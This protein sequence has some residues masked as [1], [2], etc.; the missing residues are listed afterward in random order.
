MKRPS[1]KV[2]FET[3]RK[4]AF[5]NLV[6]EIKEN[7][8]CENCELYKEVK[9]ISSVSNEELLSDLMDDEKV[10][11]P[12]TLERAYDNYE[13]KIESVTLIGLCTDI[14]VISNALLIKANF[15]EKTVAVDSSCCAGVTPAS[16]QNALEAMKVCQ[17]EIE[18]E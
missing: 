8:M 16:H 9:R 2:D 6:D 13:E 11:E 17:V 3:V 10:D 18:N 5:G 4:K 12:V 14:C 1:K 7:L 15:P